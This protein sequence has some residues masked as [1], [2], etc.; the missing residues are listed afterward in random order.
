MYKG[1]KTNGDF[2]LKNAKNV[3][4]TMNSTVA[5]SFSVTLS[6]SP[7]FIIRSSRRPH[8]ASTSK[9]EHIQKSP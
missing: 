8:V 4:F 1:R 6:L 5:A 2:F 3:P 9:T 7:G